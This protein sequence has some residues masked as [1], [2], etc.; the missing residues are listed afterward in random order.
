MVECWY[1]EPKLINSLAPT[2]LIV[3]LRDSVVILTPWNVNNF[4]Y[5]KQ[6]FQASGSLYFFWKSPLYYNFVYCEYLRFIYFPVTILVSFTSNFAHAP[7]C[8]KEHF[9]NPV[10]NIRQASVKHLTHCIAMFSS[11]ILS[12]MPIPQV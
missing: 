8:S 1:I 9:L 12:R 3:F 11:F 4:F 5:T 10:N 6:R 7:I 2:P